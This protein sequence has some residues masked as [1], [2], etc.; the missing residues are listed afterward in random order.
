M[1]P[2][3][4]PPDSEL[5]RR[6]RRDPAAFDELY[7]RH[8]RAIHAWLDR[9]VDDPTAAWELTAEVFAQAWLSRR[10]CTPDETGSAAPWLFGIAKNVHRH[11]A[12]R[13]AS[14]HR[15]MRRLRMQVELATPSDED[16]RLERM[17]VEGLK[18]ELHASLDRLPTDQRAAIELRVLEELPYEDVARRL[19]CTS[20]AAR[21]RVLRGLRT[22]NT[23]L[24]GRFT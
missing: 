4:D 5:L 23:E 11:A 19:D 10:R 22:L 17:F 12:R 3:S 15:A 9:H 6:A 16:E 18:G 14:E 21:V 20:E 1:Q 8:A 13:R 2:G 24:R 7:V